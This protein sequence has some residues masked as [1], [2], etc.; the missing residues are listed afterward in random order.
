MFLI[1]NNTGMLISNCNQQPD[2]DDLLE[3]GEFCYE[4]DGDLDCQITFDFISSSLKIKPNPPDLYHIWNDANNVWETNDELQA[5][6]QADA[7][8]EK[9]TEITSLLTH[10]A[11]KV[12]EYQDLIDF[13]ET[14]EEIST[15]E[16]GL[17]AWR[18][19]RAALLKYQK[20]LINSLPNTP[21]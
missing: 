3:R 8:A 20:G 14:P 6:K 7:E 17:L 13:A 1:F 15:G 11:R 5:Q 19:Y 10:A 12:S 9:H 16:D 2:T 21:E 18:Q 4:Y